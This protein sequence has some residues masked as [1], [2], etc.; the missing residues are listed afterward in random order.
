MT[1]RLTR[2]LRFTVDPFASDA[3]GANSYSAKPAGE[4]LGF[5]ICLDVELEG[6]VHPET[7]FVIN[8]VELDKRSRRVA[9]PLF[10]GAVRSCIAKGV[11]IT[12]SEASEVLLSCFDA[13]LPCFDAQRLTSLVLYLTPYKKLTTTG[14]N[15][16][17]YSEKFEF[18]AT[19]KLWNDK[20]SWDENFEHFG[21]CANPAGHGH[22]YIVEVSVRLDNPK[23]FLASEFQR[24]VI[25]AFID[26]LDHKNLSVD[27][28]YFSDH[29][30]TVEN[31]T[32]YCWDVL[33][34]VIKDAALQSV[35]IWENDRA[36]CTYQGDA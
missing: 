28:P 27:V 33:S 7:G 15:M 10:T 19:H 13:M 32:V 25:D 35:T 36:W 1:H 34:G 31:I 22:N 6:P 4:G 3:D 16:I 9:V 24:S 12:L 18:A 11:N 20:F 30:P 17:T 5:Y 29:N 8:L 23:A 21:K 2:Q 14:D 26:K